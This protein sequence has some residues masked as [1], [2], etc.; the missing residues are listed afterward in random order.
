MGI[1]FQ[2]IYRF[3]GMMTESER[4][5]MAEETQWYF[6]ELGAPKG[7]AE[8]HSHARIWLDLLEAIDSSVEEF[9]TYYSISEYRKSLPFYV[10]MPTYLPPGFRYR[11]SSASGVGDGKYNSVTLD[12]VQS[13]ETVPQTERSQKKRSISG[14]G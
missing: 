8:Q 13:N 10:F 6:E 7:R 14:W 5:A 9:N 11:S 3:V 1:G 12:F 4:S 2:T